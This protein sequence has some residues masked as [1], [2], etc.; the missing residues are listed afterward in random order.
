MTT[1][2][3]PLCE[4]HRC[5]LRALDYPQLKACCI[6]SL[7]HAKLAVITNKPERRRDCP[8]QGQLCTCEKL[9]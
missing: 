4:N 3:N 1:C 7:A 2:N 9:D 5:D 6:R 8:H